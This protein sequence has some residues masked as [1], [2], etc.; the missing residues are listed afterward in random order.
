VEE[1]VITVRVGEGNASL[2]G[3]EDLPF[4]E[5]YGRLFEESLA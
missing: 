5:L 2:V 3:E 1:F 4:R